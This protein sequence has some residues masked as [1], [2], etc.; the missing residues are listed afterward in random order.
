MKKLE[1]YI[2]DD[3]LY[4]NAS[5][6]K[7]EQYELWKRIDNHWNPNKFYTTNKMLEFVASQ[8]EDIIKYLEMKRC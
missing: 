1:G 6:I 3:G 5:P 7:V 8:E 4:K 2:S